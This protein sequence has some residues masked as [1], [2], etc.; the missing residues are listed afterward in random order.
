M[1]KD[2]MVCDMAEVCQ[3]L[4]RIAQKHT[5]AAS[6]ADVNELLHIAKIMESVGV[7]ADV[8]AN[9]RANFDDHIPAVARQSADYR[10]LQAQFK[11][12]LSTI[13][14]MGRKNSKTHKNEYYAGVHAGLRRAARIAI[15]FL[16]DLNGESESDGPDADE[17]R[18]A[19]A[20]DSKKSRR[21]IIR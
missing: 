18:A 6:F 14:D 2:V 17:I 11:A 13:A 3:T 9:H 20:V 10:R 19:Q 15:M 8:R 12:A 7:T 1:I 21:G 4:F 16:N 5:P